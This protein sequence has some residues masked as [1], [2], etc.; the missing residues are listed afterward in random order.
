MWKENSTENNHKMAA[1][2][3]INSKFTFVSRLPLHFLFLQKANKNAKNSQISF[4]YVYQI[5]G[6][7]Q[8]VVSPFYNACLQ[9]HALNLVPEDILACQLTKGCSTVTMIF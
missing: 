2:A 8:N 7:V 9:R 1:M 6:I 3:A 5:A 4:Y